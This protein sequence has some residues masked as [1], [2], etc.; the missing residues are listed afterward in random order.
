MIIQLLFIKNLFKRFH[1]FLCLIILYF[2]I[3]SPQVFEQSLFLFIYKRSSEKTYFFCS[4]YAFLTISLQELIFFSH[5]CP[6]LL[7]RSRHIQSRFAKKKEKRTVLFFAKWHNEPANFWLSRR[8]REI[9]GW[10]WLHRIL[11]LTSSLDRT[12]TYVPYQA[13]DVVAKRADFRKYRLVFC[14]IKSIELHHS[15]KK[16]LVDVMFIRLQSTDQEKKGIRSAWFSLWVPRFDLGNGGSVDL[17]FPH[18]SNLYDRDEQNLTIKQ[19]F[20]CSIS[21]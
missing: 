21:V 14:L 10:F 12:K 9:A 17:L 19:I 11:G 2:N 18:Y 4:R 5:V 3:L 13:S 7:I 1:S 20:F 15:A 6:A 8:R 16:Y